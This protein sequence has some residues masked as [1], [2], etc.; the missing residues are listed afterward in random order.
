MMNLVFNYAGINS[1]LFEHQMHCQFVAGFSH[2][3]AADVALPIIRNGWRQMT[4]ETR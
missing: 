4:T 2:A 3:D 1:N